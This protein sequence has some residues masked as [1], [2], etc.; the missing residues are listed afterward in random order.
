[1]DLNSL[2]LTEQGDAG[3]TMQ[4]VHPIDKTDIPGMTVRV[5][6]DK[7]ATVQAFERKRLTELTKREKVLR[8]KQ[9]DTDFTI[10]EMEELA[11]Q[12]AVI[13]VMSW[14][15]FKENGEELACTPENLAYVMKKYSWLRE[16][17]K[18]AA[19]DLENF[20]PE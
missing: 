3:Y 17:I 1:M 4:V 19:E 13:R 6:G 9:K 12:S 7:S 15:G 11:I 10:E 20:R 18:E 14:T 8:G 2:N 16:Q 5:R